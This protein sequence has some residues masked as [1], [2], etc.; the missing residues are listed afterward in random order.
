MALAIAVGVG[1]RLYQIAGQ[2]LADDEWHA[3]HAAMKREYGNIATHFGE[4]DY[5]I[6]LTLLDKAL[7][8]SLGLNE[9]GLRAPVLIAGCA[10]LVLVPLGARAFI[11]N[12]PAVLLGWL[13]AIAPMHIYFS[14][15]CRP[16][17]ITFVLVFVALTLH[18]RFQQDPKRRFFVGYLV[19]A[20]VAVALHLTVL[21][22]VGA[23]I[24]YELGA[25]LWARRSGAV[26]QRTL[27]RIVASGALTL[28]FCLGPLTPALVVNG[29]ALTEKSGAT[30][31]FHVDS[32]TG[33]I[34]LFCGTRFLLL[35]L[36]LVGLA[37]F[38]ARCLWRERPFVARRLAFCFA[39]H[40]LAIAAVR[41][42]VLEQPIVL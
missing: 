21:P 39:V 1:L 2:V 11:G 6:P 22:L 29:G 33:T 14:R 7:S 25:H 18:L 4:A 40:V 35:E 42:A 9:I 41:P 24:V 19:C 28:A 5:S 12:A 16:Y 38:G 30:G 27:F 10:A 13:L 31:D 37:A 36:V 3:V 15:Y 32:F 17:A 23:P 8:L 34:D 20:M 26:Q